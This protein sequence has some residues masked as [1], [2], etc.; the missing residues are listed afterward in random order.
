METTERSGAGAAVEPVRMRARMRTPEDV[1][2]MQRLYKLGWGKKRIA[3]E[4][5]CSVNTVRRHLRRGE[6]QPYKR[7]ERRRLCPVKW[8]TKTIVT[9]VVNQ[10]RLAA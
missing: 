5:G 4:L 1:A 7:P 3:R 10:Q 8:C 9:V 6:W 2:A